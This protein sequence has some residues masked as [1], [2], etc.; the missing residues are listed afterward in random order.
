M[1]KPAQ[2]PSKKPIISSILGSSQENKYLANLLKRDVEEVN[3]SSKP[4]ERSSLLVFWGGEDISPSLYNEEPVFTDAP[5]LPSMRDMF[6]ADLFNFAK[7]NG[8]PMLGICRGAQLLCVLG[9]GS[10][11]QHVNNHTQT[12]PIICNQDEIEATS[13]HHQMMIPTNNMKT[14]AF[15]K[16]VLSPHKY[17]EKGKQTPFTLEPEIVYDTHNKTMCIQGHPEYTKVTSPFSQLTALL[18][19]YYL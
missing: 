17:N 12:H 1:D 19:G 9:G 8:I 5:K 11:W 2:A 10:L 3:Y 7:K 18:I 6:E 13:T 4:S 15:S 16:H 14:L